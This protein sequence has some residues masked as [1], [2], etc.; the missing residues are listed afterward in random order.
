MPIVDRKLVDGIIIIS[1][2]REMLRKEALVDT[3]TRQQL[4]M[5]PFVFIRK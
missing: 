2:I 3:K 4:K 5:I 1:I